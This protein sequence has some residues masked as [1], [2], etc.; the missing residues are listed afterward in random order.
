M[1]RMCVGVC[2]AAA[3]AVMCDRGCLWAGTD[4]AI[5]VVSCSLPPRW[6]TS[7]RL[8]DLSFLIRLVVPPNTGADLLRPMHGERSTPRYVGASASC[9]GHALS[10]PAQFSKMRQAPVPHP[11]SE[12]RATTNSSYA[13]APRRWW[14]SGT[15]QATEGE[16]AAITEGTANLTLNSAN[17]G[18][19]TMMEE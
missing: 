14:T 19:L 6:W 11:P 7:W 12:A 13:T 2:P 3:A 15:G 9:F 17:E 1:R 18:D 8:T 5:P 4:T 16:R 10:V